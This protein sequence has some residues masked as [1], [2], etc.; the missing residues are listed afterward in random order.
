LEQIM[1]ELKPP[2]SAE[3]GITGIDAI[4][5]SSDG[6]AANWQA[7]QKF[8]NDWGLRENRVTQEEQSFETMS[9][10]QVFVRQPQDA[11]LSPAMEPG[12]TLREVVW[13]VQSQQE[14][15]LLLKSVTRRHKIYEVC[16]ENNSKLSRFSV[17]D[18]HGLRQSF[19]ISQQRPLQI[20]GSPSNP[21]GAEQRINSP[22]PVY[23]RAQPVEIGHVVLFTDRLGEAV[24]FYESLGFVMSDS[25]PGRGAFLRCSATAGHH[26]VFLLQ[27]PPGADGKC[28]V[29][30]NH[31]AFTVRDIHEVFGGGLAM[32]R[33]GWT[34][35]LGPGRHPISSA[36]FWYFECPVG[37]LIEYNADEDQL[38]AAWQPR[39]FTPGP[40]VFA[41]WAID[42]GIDGHTRR[43]PKVSAGGQFLT[44]KRP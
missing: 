20:Q 7:A 34:T 29:G 14:L 10:A 23:E 44:E 21:Y 37:G 35:Q 1:S 36:Y 25:Y 30:L 43:Q 16:Y 5:Y 22:S 8:F 27:L 9:G 39:E 24:A 32:S 13:A 3:S 38:T 11:R 42:G 2:S 15:D 41:E 28:K 12:A 31:I 17:L 26:D 40:T 18:P 4:V 6:T 19:R 33:A